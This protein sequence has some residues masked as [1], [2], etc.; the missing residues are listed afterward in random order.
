MQAWHKLMGTLPTLDT[1]T[2]APG[3]PN[4]PSQAQQ[5]KDQTSWAD[6][7]AKGVTEAA[8]GTGNYATNNP[9]AFTANA[10]LAAAQ[11]RYLWKTAPGQKWRDVRLGAMNTVPDPGTPAYETVAP[12][13]P[14]EIDPATRT[15]YPPGTINPATG[16]PY[17]PGTPDP[18]T[19]RPYPPGSMRPPKM[20]PQ[21]D[22]KD[23]AAARVKRFVQDVEPE[24]G[25][26]G[27]LGSRMGPMQD[28]RWHRLNPFRRWNEGVLGSALGDLQA[29]GVPTNPLL[30]GVRGNPRLPG[31]LDTI[32]G[33]IGNPNAPGSGRVQL[34]PMIDTSGTHPTAGPGIGAG[35]SA[36][37]HAGQTARG[38]PGA[39]GPGL[40]RKLG[41]GALYLAP[42]AVPHLWN[43]LTNY[44]NK[45][46]GT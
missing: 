28:W 39:A 8:Q 46:P 2:G 5:A 15:P 7:G 42:H 24:L 11:G 12:R 23:M 26:M 27:P 19:G 25:R 40:G 33:Q 13:E 21:V 30:A 6:I 34:A 43:A 36:L 38:L 1:G 10:A 9:G 20:V 31:H 16:A 4:A 35:I 29:G 17:L 37:E 32:R 44:W 3:T 41:R 22:P 18:T 45:E 14:Y